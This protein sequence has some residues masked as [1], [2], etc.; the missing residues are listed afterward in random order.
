MLSLLN[1][2]GRPMLTAVPDYPVNGVD[3]L[4]QLAAHL[5][6]SKRLELA[7]EIVTAK[8]GKPVPGYVSSLNHLM[9]WE[10]E[11]AQRYWQGLGIVRDYP[12]ARDPTNLAINY[13]FGLLETA[14][15]RSI[16]RLGLEPA[17]GFLHESRPSFDSKSA[18]VYDVMEPFRDSA[19]GVALAEP[20]KRSDYYRM[21]GYGLRL[22]E[23]AA[24]RLAQRFAG[25]VS[26]KEIVDWL[27][28]FS[29]RF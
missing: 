9:M 27:K 23:R 21:F 5:D 14:V 25:A 2:N 18:F 29:L 6:P 12:H 4:S 15:R 1:L 24:K 8:T 10:A 16:H 17:V 22:R 11:Q 19:V 7:K 13:C 3:R 20:L 26:D 28:R